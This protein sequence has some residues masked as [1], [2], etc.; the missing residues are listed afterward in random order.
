MTFA[1]K[2]N[3]ICACKTID[4]ERLGELLPDITKT[5]PHIFSSTTVFISKRQL[6]EMEAIIGTIEEVI[7]KKGYQ[8]QA[9]KR[10]PTIAHQDRGPHGVFMGYDF[11]LTDQ[12]AKLIEINTNAGGGLLNLELAKAQKISCEELNVFFDVPE[13]P[14]KVEKAFVDMFLHEWALQGKPG[15]PSLIAIVDERPAE[16]YLYPEF[17]LFEKLFKKHCLNAVVADPSELLFRNNDLWYNNEKV[18]LVYNRLTD[19]Y[20]QEHTDIKAAYEAGA[21]VLTPSPYHHALYANKL[22]LETLTTHSELQ[23]LGVSP[24][25]ISILTQGIPQTRQVKKEEASRLWEQRKHLFFKPAS[26]YGSKAA[27][28]GDKIT[29]KVFEDVMAGDYVAQTLAPPGIRLIQLDETK[30]DYKMDIR[31]Y[32]YEGKIQLM[33]AR[34]YSGQT[35]NFRSPGGGFAPVFVLD[36]DPTATNAS[37]R[38]GGRLGT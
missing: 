37:I 17:Q 14:G 28:R 25:G 21:I 3:R 4:Q 23:S 7:K 11:H 38:Q 35:T 18:D 5:H 33:A 20:L 9:L 8:D 6:G 13:G 22:N 2:L 12:G 32:V 30:S 36:T 26:G 16:Q 27:Y 1:L 34:L 15:R 24:E 29:K 19:F 31:A 10:S